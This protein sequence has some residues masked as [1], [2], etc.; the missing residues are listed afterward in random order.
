LAGRAVRRPAL[1][2]NINRETAMRG[3]QQR[4][5]ERPGQHVYRRGYWYIAGDEVM[6]VSAGAGM[7]ANGLRAYPFRIRAS[8]QIVALGT[9][10]TTGAAG[11][12]QLGIYP[13]SKRTLQPEGLPVAVTGDIDVSAAANVS[14]AVI[15]G[16]ALLP[17]GVY[18][19]AANNNIGALVAQ[20]G[21][22]ATNYYG[23]LVGSAS[24]DI[25]ASGSVN[26]AAHRFASATYGFWPDLSKG[27]MA[28]TGTSPYALGQF[29]VAP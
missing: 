26:A 1:S 17:R 15:G 27:T 18:W 9:R 7:P 22:V 19:F 16:S 14:G 21:G 11:L 20:V 6:L 25:I 4:V 28:E 13:A 12:M 23:T 10:I 3:D 29:Q 24:Q 5:Q 2:Q 8:V